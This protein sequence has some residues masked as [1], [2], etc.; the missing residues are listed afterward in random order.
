MINQRIKQ[1]YS[2][3][4]RLAERR[5]QQGGT[6]SGGEQQ[7]LAIGRAMV[8]G[9]KLLMLDEPSMGLAPL[10]VAQVMDVVR[11]I[12]EQGTSVLLIEQNA[13]SALRVATRGY[14]IDSGVVTI[15]APAEQLRA[16]PR[17]VEAYLGK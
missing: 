8:S 2:L 15:E 5:S 14:V 12:R 17:V 11:D 6:L 3:L 10:M 7:M 1:V 13:R 16:D 4:P 9:P